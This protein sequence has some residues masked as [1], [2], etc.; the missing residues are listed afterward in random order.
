MNDY[1]HVECLNECMFASTVYV[2]D[3]ASLVRFMFKNF[4][5]MYLHVHGASF[6]NV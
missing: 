6:P 5:F 2:K 3:Y 4:G 1:E